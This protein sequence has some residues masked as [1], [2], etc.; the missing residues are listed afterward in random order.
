MYPKSSN[1]INLKGGIPGKTMLT[2]LEKSIEILLTSRN[3]I[4]DTIVRDTH[5]HT[6]PAVT[7]FNMLSGTISEKIPYIDTR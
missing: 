4:L 5:P 3:A 7:V 2:I 1:C 6:A